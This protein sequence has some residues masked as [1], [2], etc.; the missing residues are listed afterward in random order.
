M[1]RRVVD[2]QDGPAAAAGRSSV[3]STPST[4]VP[5]FAQ[6]EAAGVRGGEIR[7]RLGVLS[8]TRLVLLIGG[9]AVEGD[10]AP[11]DVVGDLVRKKVP[12]EVSAAAR[13]DSSPILGVPAGAAALEAIGVDVAAARA[14]R[15]RFAYACV[16]WSERRPHL[17]G[18]LLDLALRRR[19]VTRD[20]DGRALTVTAFGRRELQARFGVT[21][22]AQTRAE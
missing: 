13:D 22:A 2:D 16:D 19:W 15:R 18:A 4:K 6:D 14:A 9:E 11:A 5:L 3:P 8:E 12:D 10:Q 1:A 7:A 21:A 20:L 17:G